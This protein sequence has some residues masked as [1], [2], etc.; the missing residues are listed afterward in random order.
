M[1]DSTFKFVKSSVLIRGNLFASF[2]IHQGHLAVMVRTRKDYIHID[3]LILQ[4]L[5]LGRG[6][7]V[8]GMV[9]GVVDDK[10]SW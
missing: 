9:S 10:R 4:Q 8:R 2:L 6:A 7:G 1:H 5:G 3:S